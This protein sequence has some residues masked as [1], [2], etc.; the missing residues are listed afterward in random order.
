MSHTRLSAGGAL[1]LVEEIDLWASEWN[2]SAKYDP[3]H[4]RPTNKCWGSSERRLAPG[5]RRGEQKEAKKASWG[6][7]CVCMCVSKCPNTHML[8]EVG[9][10]GRWRD[11]KGKPPVGNLCVKVQM[12]RELGGRGGGAMSTWVWLAWGREGE[13]GRV[14]S[15][16]A[17]KRNQGPSVHL[18][19]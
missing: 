12:R 7:Q 5:E 14:V 13:Q 2:M 8:T 11:P 9:K 15:D 18:F 17:R 19:S 10:S 6:K 1:S 4:R 16:I 3:S